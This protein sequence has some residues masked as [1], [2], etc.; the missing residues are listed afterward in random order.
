MKNGKELRA[1][2]LQSNGGTVWSPRSELWDPRNNQNE[3]NIKMR[4][5][6]AKSLLWM[7]LVSIAMCSL[8]TTI[9]AEGPGPMPT[10]G[11]SQSRR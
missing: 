10:G 11:P 4:T 5:H 9:F 6:A 1:V 7:L 3:R 8:S 2:T